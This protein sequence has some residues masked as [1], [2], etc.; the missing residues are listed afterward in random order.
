MPT[1]TRKHWKLCSLADIVRLLAFTAVVGVLG[2]RMAYAYRPFDGTDAAVAETGEVE[3]EIGVIGYQREGREKS[4]LT[5]ALVANWGLPKDR[6]IVL[7]GRLRRLSDNDAQASNTR[8][9]DVALSLKQVHRRGSLQDETGP[10]VAS[11]CGVL[12]PTTQDEPHM[13]AICDL[14]VSQR[15]SAATVHLN[16]ALALNRDRHAS[17][18]LGAIVE[19]PQDWRL[20][21]VMEVFTEKTSGAAQ[22]TSVLVGVIWPVRKNLA[23]DFGVRS[24]HAD[25]QY[26]NELRAG[27]TWSLP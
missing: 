25:R 12:L 16:T 11:E 27:F 5:P 10:S 18:F 8:L 1:M 20:R 23:V 4:W 13:G 9:V 2:P 24:A 7:E 26:T 22:M 17:R 19:G 3:L 15:W 21:P 14:I 6:E